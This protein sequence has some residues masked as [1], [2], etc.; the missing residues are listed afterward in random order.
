MNNFYNMIFITCISFSFIQRVFIKCKIN[1]QY[2]MNLILVLIVFAPS[3]NVNGTLINYIDIISPIIFLYLLFSIK[4]ENN[5][6]V[7]LDMYLIIYGMIIVISIIISFFMGNNEYF[8]TIFRSYRF[9]EIIIIYLFAL[10]YYNLN[11]LESTIKVVLVSGIISALIGFINFILR[12]PM[13]SEQY[14]LFNHE[15][16]Y[17]AG[18]VYQE[19]NSFANMMLF[20]IIFSLIIL[21]QKVRVCRKIRLISIINLGI[22]LMSLVVSFSRGPIVAILFTIIII[23]ICYIKNNN[24]KLFKLLLFILTISL[25]TISL[26]EEISK[27]VNVF[28]NDRILPLLSINKQNINGISSGRISIWLNLIKNFLRLNLIMILFGTGYKASTIHLGFNNLSDNN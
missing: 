20:N 14:I 17:R 9:I 28:F 2:L 7:N 24:L 13:Q 22:S 18:G 23:M 25:I 8:N 19:A 3:I 10:K 6:K 26:N 11:W 15:L 27:L 4:K 5:I 21:I 12:V 16:I 1:K